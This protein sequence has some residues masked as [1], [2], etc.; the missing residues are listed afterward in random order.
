M[1]VEA[2]TLASRRRNW[3][4]CIYYQLKLVILKIKS[5][6]PSKS[7]QIK[8]TQKR[9]SY[10][11][12]F[13]IYISQRFL[14]R[15]QDLKSIK[16]ILP[17]Q[18]ERGERVQQIIHEFVTQ[19]HERILSQRTF[20]KLAKIKLFIV[21]LFTGVSIQYMHTSFFKYSYTPHGTW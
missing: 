20:Q 15:V 12:Y 21:C 18:Y 2:G 10:F 5:K 3:L 16:V 6:K 9:Y 11:T 14:E 7:N 19:C 1:L 17:H 13:K 4:L 8:R